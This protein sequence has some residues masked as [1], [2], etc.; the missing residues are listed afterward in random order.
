MLRKNI[1]H[2]TFIAR[3]VMFQKRVPYL[4]PELWKVKGSS[5]SN[6]Q[7]NKIATT[8]TPPTPTLLCYFF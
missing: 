8:P 5:K 4:D 6:K 1:T 7:S 3:S 2:E